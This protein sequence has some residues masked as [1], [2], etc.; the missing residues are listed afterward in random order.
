M[1][2][3]ICTCCR[4][5][6]ADWT[7]GQTP[8]KSSGGGILVNLESAKSA[9][10]LVPTTGSRRRQFCWKNE[11]IKLTSI[12][13][14][15]LVL[16]SMFLVF[17]VH[18][19]IAWQ[20]THMWLINGT[21]TVYLYSNMRWEQYWKHKRLVLECQNGRDVLFDREMIWL[22]M[23][24]PPAL[25]PILLV[26]LTVPWV[27]L[28]NVSP[29]FDVLLVIQS[30]QAFTC[31]QN[32]GM[33]LLHLRSTW[34]LSSSRRWTSSTRQ[35]PWGWSRWPPRRPPWWWPHLFTWQPEDIY[36]VLL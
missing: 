26:L 3:S 4:G 15:V 36:I 24:A 22:D 12:L 29:L 1:T 25:L 21:G 33:L 20:D 13:L 14:C 18:N 5:I 8:F 2:E 19:N 28:N 23:R 6:T 17:S 27:G 31:F 9:S 16:T 35:S 32:K 7:Y 10:N 30:C 11:P 34:Y